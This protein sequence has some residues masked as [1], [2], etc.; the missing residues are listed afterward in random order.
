MDRWRSEITELHE[1]LE[2]LQIERLK[3][4]GLLEEHLSPDLV[5]ELLDGS[6]AL[7]LG[8]TRETVGVLFSN[9]T[10]LV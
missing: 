1:T 2:K 5:A 4:I 7:K 10:A 6:M 8:G 3:L 9:D